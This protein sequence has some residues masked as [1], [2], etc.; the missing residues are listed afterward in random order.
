[1]KFYVRG[2]ILFEA[3]FSFKGTVILGLSVA[4]VERNACDNGAT[5]AQ[6]TAAS[7]RAFLPPRPKPSSEHAS[8][9]SCT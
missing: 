8:E 7:K 1:M 2:L 9:K 3:I 6:V 4:L 5:G